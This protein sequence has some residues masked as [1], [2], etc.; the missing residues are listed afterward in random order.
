MLRL[1]ILLFT[2]FPLTHAAL[3]DFER[4]VLDRNGDV[5]VLVTMKN[6]TPITPAVGLYRFRKVHDYATTRL[7]VS[8][9]PGIENYEGLAVDK[10][11]HVKFFRNEGDGTAVKDIRTVTTK[12]PASPSAYPG[13]FSL[14]YDVQGG[15]GCSAA[16]MIT[17]DA[18]PPG[19]VFVIERGG[20]EGWYPLY[21]ANQNVGLT[22]SSSNAYK[23]TLNAN[24]FAADTIYLPPAMGA[25]D[26]NAILSYHGGFWRDP[27]ARGGYAIQ[28]NANG[29]AVY[30]PINSFVLTNVPT[31]THGNCLRP[32]RVSSVKKNRSSLFLD[33]YMSE[34]DN[35]LL[36]DLDSGVFG[37]ATKAKFNMQSGVDF[38]IAPTF[39]ASIDGRLRP[40]TEALNTSVSFSPEI[41]RYNACGDMCGQD[42]IPQ[43][44][45]P[46]TINKG[47]AK[48]SSGGAN[49]SQ[50][51]SYMVE[52]RTVSSGASTTVET[53]VVQLQYNPTTNKY[54]KTDIIR[55]QGGSSI[56]LGA[57]EISGD[58]I[59]RS[60]SSPLNVAMAPQRII[61]YDFAGNPA[62]TRS[63]QTSKREYSQ[64]SPVDG[65][66]YI[67]ISNLAASHF[68]VSSSFWGTGGVVWWAVANA[69]NLKIYFEQSNHVSGTILLD[70]SAT[71]VEASNATPLM[72]LGADGD[73][74]VYIMHLGSGTDGTGG[75]E[76]VGEMKRLLTPLTGDRIIQLCNQGRVVGNCPAFPLDTPAPGGTVE[77]GLILKV[78]A[79]AMVEKIAPL[80]GS[81]PVKIGVI[82]LDNT[83]GTCTTLL[84][85]RDGNLDSKTD[86]PG[87]YKNPWSCTAVGNVAQNI[88]DKYNFEMSIIN[89]ANP[90]AT[91]GSFNLDIVA[92]QTSSV[93]NGG[94]TNFQEDI[95][96]TFYMENPPVF[97][98]LKAQLGLASDPELSVFGDVRMIS[99]Y[100]DVGINLARQNLQNLGVEDYFYDNDSRMGTLLPSFVKS[101]G[102]L[103]GNLLHTTVGPVSAPVASLSN[104]RYRW[105]ILARTP[106][107]SFKDYGAASCTPLLNGGNG[108]SLINKDHLVGTG[109]LNAG[110]QEVPYTSV[111]VL[112][113]TCWKDL[114]DAN[115]AGVATDGLDPEAIPFTFE[116]PGIYDVYLYFGGTRFNA[117]EK[118]FL[119]LA[120]S[121]SAE[122]AVTWYA[123]EIQ[124]GARP[125]QTSDEIQ[126]VVISNNFLSQDQET[127]AGIYPNGADTIAEHT[128]QVDANVDDGD[129]LGPEGR[130][131][132]LA[133]GNHAKSPAPLV[134]TYQD[135]RTPIV[136]EAE[137]QFFR[138]VD[139]KYDAI[140]QSVLGKQ[141]AIQTKYKGVGAWDYKYPGGGTLTM[142]NI[143]FSPM[144]KTATHPS[145]WSTSSSQAGTRIATSDRNNPQDEERRGYDASGDYETGK[146]YVQAGNLI[147][148]VGAD[149]QFKAAHQG[150]LASDDAFPGSMG[151]VTLN[152]DLI[153]HPESFYTW[154]EIK[155]AWFMRYTRPDGT[156]GKKII[157]TGNLAEI[158]MMNLMIKK[159]G[160]SW[161]QLVKNLAPYN[162]SSDGK[163]VPPVASPL[164]WYLG[165]T[166]AE[167]RR[168]RKVRVRIPLFNS[169]ALLN[170][171][172]VLTEMDSPMRSFSS[173]DGFASLYS[174]IH[175]VSFPVPSEP[176]ILEIGFQLFYPVMSWEG[177]DEN[178]VGSGDYRYY[179]AVYW[180]PASTAAGKHN[181]AD[182]SKVSLGFGP[183][184]ISVWPILA[185]Q[186]TLE[187]GAPTIPPDA[188][189]NGFGLE[190][191]STK[192][193]SGKQRVDG[194]FKTTGDDVTYNEPG[195]RVDHF[196][197]V[198][199]L[200]MKAPKMSVIEG[201]NLAATSGGR[202]DGDIVLEVTDNNPYALWETYEDVGN[203]GS[204]GTPDDKKRV[205]GL[206]HF[207]YEIGYDPKVHYG[208][209]LNSAAAGPKG[210]RAY[211]FNLSFTSLLTNQTQLTNQGNNLPIFDL[212]RTG[213]A[214]PSVETA[215]G[216]VYNPVSIAAN[217]FMYPY[218]VPG[219]GFP[220]DGVFVERIPQAFTHTTDSANNTESWQRMN[221]FAN[222]SK[223]YP[224]TATVGADA[225]IQN[226]MGT[227]DQNIRTENP[228]VPH[229]GLNSWMISL[230]PD[231]NGELP[232]D[233]DPDHQDNET[234][235]EFLAENPGSAGP[236][237]YTAFDPGCLNTNTP[238]DANPDNCSIK[239]RWR[240]QSQYLLTPYFVNGAQPNPGEGPMTYNVYAKARD[241]RISK[242]YP[243]Y[244]NVPSNI[245]WN[246]PGSDW[247]NGN[248][249]SWP[250]FLFGTS[251]KRRQGMESYGEDGSLGAVGQTASA[252]IEN[253][254]NRYYSNELQKRAARV[255]KIVVADN[256]APNVRVTLVE[257]KYNKK[258]EYT[259]MSAQGYESDPTVNA[260][261]DS[262]RVV[263]F[264][265]EDKRDANN[266]QF[267]S[268]PTYEELDEDTYRPGANSPVSQFRV[269]DVEPSTQHKDMAFHVPEDV[270]FMVKVEA[271]DNKDLDGIDISISSAADG[272]NVYAPAVPAIQHI[273]TDVGGHAFPSRASTAGRVY[274]QA[275]ILTTYHLYPNA[276]FY[277]V[278][279][280]DVKDGAGNN[281]IM[282]IPIVVIPQ[283]VH[284]RQLGD[285]TRVR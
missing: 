165:S 244:T 53:W 275:K 147:S 253:K 282:D 234:R 100:E 116:D 180:G 224:P 90:P 152:K 259:L 60:G 237:G 109:F 222:R 249:G 38:D 144:D 34:D 111:G 20:Q 219:N 67:Y 171:T 139:L 207:A 279:R 29:D 153:D 248:F 122:V 270:R 188:E 16:R 58:G 98:G 131:P 221:D 36:Q 85:F 87:I 47:R 94:A 129:L 17:V 31:C 173:S 7:G 240:V 238:L 84:E 206:V 102:Q 108:S 254:I 95:S 83:G 170:S 66:D 110:F 61:I 143:N 256:D 284:F 193:I 285:Q 121:I 271:T 167:Q 263:F 158:F 243:N 246:S 8:D 133:V 197:D 156:V 74:F 266:P 149:A 89:V 227:Q 169:G 185:T 82:P 273:S 181:P 159:G 21:A 189:A 187:P 183:D 231:L 26:V 283:G 19:W 162:L 5:Y 114:E 136:A 268:V 33:E 166:A 265:T 168:D 6:N 64:E 128:N 160:T 200:D 43:Q 194:G 48:F 260:N 274:Q 40:A 77:Q 242:D 258:V 186:R 28:Y 92:Q 228:T 81:S 96:Y 210:E 272:L 247:F 269:N 37:N 51:R 79:G 88:Q 163:P 218:K 205:P 216:F 220:S 151:G 127:R 41:F 15:F 52:T 22:G 86:G 30:P 178:P 201:Q 99:N 46:I 184:A 23:Y 257:F 35:S 190:L 236:D 104:L 217:D 164:M 32:A 239:T 250:N 113:D 63:V 27:C 25:I 72:A 264:R 157:K 119:D 50:Q 69:A 93:T 277:D 196:V 150:T 14:T 101:Q 211:G 203:D 213:L 2:L 232:Y 141:D 229:P 13:T 146:G 161:E 70:G 175:P 195:G 56:T 49:Q 235:V 145:N 130:F 125:A 54:D 10:F 1:L 204:S 241:V 154:W 57:G 192:N 68:N 134:V 233:L 155:Y 59:I 172:D 107:H 112:R 280:V 251:W 103:L 182:Y 65:K 138:I 245:N 267:D 212:S 91:A 140:G 281:R 208:I 4:A 176:T 106:P 230:V 214:T 11:G 126:E 62:Y 3:S 117:D 78:Y 223:F 215:P 97:N 12:H 177:R 39:D 142:G 179:D 191:S 225:A 80:P 255:A 198:A 45:P 132:V 252:G 24:T 105:R 124:V 76:G 261:Q 209:G 199:V 226:Y 174:S 18:T 75:V 44:V 202:A 278:L 123:M 9:K 42:G 148:A 118:T 137:V 115:P 71:P 135:Q 276:N 120:S 262:D 73:N 55:W